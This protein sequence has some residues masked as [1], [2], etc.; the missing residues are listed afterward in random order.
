[1]D[2][3]QVVR[4]SDGAFRC[5]ECG[6]RYALSG[7][8]MIRVCGDGVHRFRTAALAIPVEL[9]GRRSAPAVW[10]PNAYCA[11]MADAAELIEGRVRRVAT[12]DGPF[13]AGYDQDDAA[14]QGRF[15][16]RPLEPSLERIDAAVSRFVD[17]V[18]NLDDVG[19]ARSGNHEEAGAIRL[20]DIAHDMPHELTHHAGDLAR[21]GADLA[22]AR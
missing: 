3:N 1:V 18:S 21:I 4:D 5:R 11:H 17:V 12:E 22:Q 15:D 16:E 20:V 8:E 6:F 9:R 7:P 13:L 14:E 10:S 2:P 19:W